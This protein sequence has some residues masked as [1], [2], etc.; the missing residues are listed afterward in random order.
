MKLYQFIKTNLNLF[1]N[2][3]TIPYNDIGVE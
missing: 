3:K 2:K 1:R